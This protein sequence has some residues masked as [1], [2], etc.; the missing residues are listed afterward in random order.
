MKDQRSCETAQLVELRGATGLPSLLP[1]F[2]APM[3]LAI[4]LLKL[5]LIPGNGM[6]HRRQQGI[7]LGGTTVFHRRACEH[8]D[9][10]QP[11]MTRQPQQS[12][13]AVRL[14]GLSEMCLIHHQQCSRR[15]KLCRQARPT[16]QGRLEIHHLR[17][18]TPVGMQSHRRHHHQPQ[19]SATGHGSRRQQRRQRFSQP[20]LIGKNGTSSCQKPTG[21][22]ALMGQRTTAVTQRRLQISRRHQIT[23]GWQRRQRLVVPIQPLLQRGGDRESRAKG[24]EQGFRCG[25]GELPTPRWPH[26]TTTRSDPPQLRLRDSVERTDHADESGGREVKPAGGQSGLGNEIPRKPSL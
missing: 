25:H 24:L 23:V 22:A 19:R 16:D 10:P 8:P 26:P 5:T 14:Q 3:P 2:L 18:P 21:P 20:H 6:V 12:R 9:R 17:F 1:P 4:A 15:W 13:R 11:G 7:Q